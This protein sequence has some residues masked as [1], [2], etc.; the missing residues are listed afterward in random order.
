MK[1]PLI[2]HLKVAL[3]CT[4][5]AAAL[6]LPLLW[7]P[8]L[9][10]WPAWRPPLINP[11]VEAVLAVLAAAWTAWCVVDIQRRGLK[12]L[13]LVATLWLLGSGIWLS[14][15]YGYPI[16]SIAP[17]TAA[18]LAGVG[19]FAF[20]FTSMGSRRARW[21]S[22]VGGRVA[23]E[24]LHE[25]IDER[26]LEEEPQAANVAVLEVLWPAVDS[27]ADA[28]R[29]VET[30]AARAAEHFQAVG[31][32]V[33]RCDAEGARFVF[34]LWGQAVVLPELVDATW[35]WVGQAGGCAALTRGECLA[36][37]ARMPGDTRWTLSGAPLR[38]AARMA[39]SARGYAAKL[40]LEDA[41]AGE[42]AEAWSTRRM[43]WWDFE[44]E[45]ILLREVTGP[46][47]SDDPA[48][49]EALRRWERAWDDF[50]AG[51]WPSA[52]NAFAALAREQDDAAARV[53]ALRS[54]QA[55]R[56]DAG[57]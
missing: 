57:S 3:L 50:W 48:R 34:G 46:T 52:G 17:L 28:W 49:A 56:Q 5:A 2:L 38:R 29:E 55:R 19:A 36:G 30:A 11:R 21:H 22:L 15:L 10:A 13:I 39:A 20:S 37:V 54:E 32:Y 9:P 44:G 23:P 31:G 51:D 53:F 26:P 43:A 33:E 40:L 25:H 7:L 4:L 16:L 18:G 42:L 12:L 8:Q 24:L 14:C 1:R 35:K 6:A 45:A 27:S 41:A 47:V